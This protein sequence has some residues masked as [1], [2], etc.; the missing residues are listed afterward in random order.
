MT[1]KPDKPVEEL[2]LDRRLGEIDPDDRAWIEDRLAADPQVKAMNAALGRTL[3]ALDAHWTPPP[4]VNLSEKVL[5]YVQSDRAEASPHDRIMPPPLEAAPGRVSRFG[6]RDFI[7]V[8]ACI[9]LII[10]AL[11]PAMQRMRS[12]AR[13]VQCVGNL[14][15]IS[16]AV[17]AYGADFS[18]LLPHAGVPTGASWL[19][20]SPSGAPH[21][22]NS[23]HAYLLVRLGYLNHESPFRCPEGRTA[24]GLGRS[25]SG[26]ADVILPRAG[27]Q[28]QDPSRG[29]GPVK[30]DVINIGE[31]SADRRRSDDVLRLTYP[32]LTD[33][34]AFPDACSY[35]GLNMLGVTP[36]LVDA[37]DQVYLGDPNPLFLGGMFRPS[38]NP[39]AT[40]SPLHD[41]GRGQNVLLLDGSVGWLTSP[42]RNRTDNVWLAGEIQDYRGTE[43]QSDPHDAF[44]VPATPSR[45]APPAPR[46]GE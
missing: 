30:F 32:G 38:I 45:G 7:A 23:R 9:G 17:S 43:A 2:L 11:A 6:L 21:Q 42:F 25:G 34:F 12:E 22:S 10:T 19:Y 28:P 1:P 27:T 18:G 36:R 13:R 20:L 35:D 37:P 24:S 41:G 15:T 16:R 44:L 46:G 5:R 29:E 4:P 14:E 33:D 8:A 3:E 39:N 31:L 26:S 40:N